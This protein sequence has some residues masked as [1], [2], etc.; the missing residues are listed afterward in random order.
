MLVRTD[1]AAPYHEAFSTLE[2]T[3]TTVARRY[4]HWKLDFSKTA[5]LAQNFTTHG[6]AAV[7]RDTEGKLRLPVWHG[8]QL[9]GDLG[10]RLGLT[11]AQ[12]WTLL[13]KPIS[14]AHIAG[15][16]QKDA[17]TW[18]LGDLCPILALFTLFVWMIL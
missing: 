5:L 12:F 18:C 13:V 11:A 7:V 14:E 15:M 17:Q 6:A 3:I 9:H 4:D 2:G 10:E 8:F 1:I 16:S